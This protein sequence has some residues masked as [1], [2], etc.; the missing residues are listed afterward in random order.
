MSALDE[1]ATFE[2]VREKWKKRYIEPMDEDTLAL[3]MEELGTTLARVNRLCNMLIMQ[4][5]GLGSGCIDAVQD[6]KSAMSRIRWYLE[7]RDKPVI[8]ENIDAIRTLAQHHQEDHDELGE[9]ARKILEVLPLG[10][11]T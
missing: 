3:L 10:S 5:K 4:P 6:M 7:Q 1:F 9:A 8:R 11:E 2:E